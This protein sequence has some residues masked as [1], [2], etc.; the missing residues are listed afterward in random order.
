MRFLRNHAKNVLIDTDTCDY[1]Q[2]L[3]VKI[4]RNWAMLITCLQLSQMVVGVTINVYS[5]WIKGQFNSQ[6][7]YTQF[8]LISTILKPNLFHNIQ[9]TCYASYIHE[10]E[11]T[12][13]LFSQLVS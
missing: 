2:S 9:P 4:P 8:S 10:S 11:C 13:G 1:L 5:L 6:L 3:R 7:F 12:H